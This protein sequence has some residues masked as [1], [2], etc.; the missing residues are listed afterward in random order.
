MD[1]TFDVLQKG[2]IGFVIQPQLLAQS[3]GT[4]FT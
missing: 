4:V 1:H 3:S 2:T